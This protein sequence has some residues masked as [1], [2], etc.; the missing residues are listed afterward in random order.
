MRKWILTF[1]LVL[2]GAQA[3]LADGVN[4]I[5]QVHNAERSAVGVPPLVWDDQLMADAYA[6]AKTILGSANPSHSPRA[7]Y[8]YGENIA[9]GTGTSSST[10]AMLSIWTN[11][12]S[13]F[14]NGNKFPDDVAKD[15]NWHNVAHYTQMIW[16]NTTK[17]G[18]GVAS[19]FKLQKR[20]LVCRYL[21]PGNRFGQKVY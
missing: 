5:L 15:G 13:D 2:A 7:F 1:A 20:V 21:P 19:S 12:K 6:Y 10:S 9:W 18:C 8:D 17:V 3:S 4:E 16:K 11:E 14:I